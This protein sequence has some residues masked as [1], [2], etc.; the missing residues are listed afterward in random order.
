[1]TEDRAID[2][3]LDKPLGILMPSFSSQ[4]TISGVAAPAYR[5]LSKLYQQH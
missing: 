3:V 1:M 2:I 4:S 5:R